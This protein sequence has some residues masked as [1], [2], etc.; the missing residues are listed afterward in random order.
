[1]GM[2][3]IDKDNGTQGLTDEQIKEYKRNTRYRRETTLESQIR[4]GNCSPAQ[5]NINNQRRK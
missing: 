2:C 1:M 4:E 3:Y 5:D